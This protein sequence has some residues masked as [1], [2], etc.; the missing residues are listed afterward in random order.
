MAYLPFPTT[1]P[2][3]T[4]KDKLA[5]WFESYAELMDLNVWMDSKIESST[6]SDKESLWTISIKRGNES[7]RTL[8]PKHVIFST[9]HSGE[10]QIPTFPNQ[11]IYQ[12]IIYHASQHKDASSHGDTK[13]KNVVV[14][15]T[16]NSGHDIAQNFYDNGANVTMLQRSSTHVVTADVGLPIMTEALYSENSPA[17]EDADIYAQSFPIPVGLALARMTTAAIGQADGE[18]LEGL[19]KAGFRLNTGVNGAG[20]SSLYFTRGGGYYIDTGCSKLIIDGK[21]RMEHSPSGIEGFDKD[22]LI[23]ADGQ[24]LQADI[25]VLATGYDDMRTSLQKAL[26]SEVASRSKDVWGLD[27]EAELKTV[28]VL[29][30]ILRNSM[31]THYCI[32]CGDPVVILGCGIWVVICLYAGSIRNI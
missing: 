10:P 15:G 17:T 9:G 2:F 7:P 4:P 18:I 5:S 21:I 28:S 3:F 12:G 1:W 25:V 11:E 23:L 8:H 29:S 19:A 20:L 27:E 6:W 24:K 32:R 14:V 22:S 16:G 30:L 26:G 31:L 13:G